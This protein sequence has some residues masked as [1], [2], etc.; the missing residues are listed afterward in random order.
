MGMR[1]D[2]WILGISMLIRLASRRVSLPDP[3]NLEQSITQAYGSGRPFSDLPIP[4]NTLLSICDLHAYWNSEL[5]TWISFW[6]PQ[7]NLQDWI[8]WFSIIT[9]ELLT[10]TLSLSHRS[11]DRPEV[12]FF[13]FKCYLARIDWS[14]LRDLNLNQIL[15]QIQNVLSAWSNLEPWE[16]SLEKFWVSSLKEL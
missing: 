11:S 8:R 13:G 16:V 14:S 2:G 6:I 15:N 10:H 1:L 5:D 9:P 7:V 4:R 12:V 3:S